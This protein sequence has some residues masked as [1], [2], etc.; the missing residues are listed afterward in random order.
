VPCK[1]GRGG[2]ER[3]IEIALTDAERTELHKSA[4]AVRATQA[5]ID[6]G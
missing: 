1:L 5:M 4:A 2:L 3:I 6:A